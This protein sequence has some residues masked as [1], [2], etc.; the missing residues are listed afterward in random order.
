MSNREHLLGYLEGAREIILPGPQVLPTE[1]LRTPGLNG[2]KMSKSYD[3]MIRIR[4]DK[5][6]IERKVRTMPTDPACVHRIDPDDPDKYPVW[7]LYQIYSD[8]STK[9]WMQKGCRS[10]DIGCLECK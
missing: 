7:Q 9:E 8:V 1:T 10:V 2:Q 4:K 3:N 6:T 5:G